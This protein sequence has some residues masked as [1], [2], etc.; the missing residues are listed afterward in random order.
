M[1]PLRLRDFLATACLAIVTL[2]QAPLLAAE[3][4]AARDPGWEGYNNRLVPEVTPLVTQDFGYTRT[5][6]AAKSPGEIGGRITRA[7]E[8]AWYAA[9]IPPKTLDDKLAASGNFTITEGGGAVCCGWFNGQHVLYISPEASNAAAGGP[10]ANFSALLAQSANS[11][12]AVPIYVV[13]NFKQ[14]NVIPSAPLPTGP[15]SSASSGYSP[16]WQVNM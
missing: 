14:G 3:P 15:T 6:F 8:P 4:T 7:S 5:N 9:K 1:F 12:A 10:E 16:L 2:R 11:T 13:S